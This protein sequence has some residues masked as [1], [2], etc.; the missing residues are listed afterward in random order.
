MKV[1][2]NWAVFKEKLGIKNVETKRAHRIAKE[3]N[4]PSLK[5]T[6]IP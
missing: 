5:R 3:R 6:I 2:Q 1:I 4:D